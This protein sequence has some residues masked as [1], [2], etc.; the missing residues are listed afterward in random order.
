MAA[1]LR[2]GQPLNGTLTLSDASEQERSAIDQFLGRRPSSGMPMVVRL[3]EMERV[4]REGGICDSLCEAVQAI[5]G[6]IEN[7]RRVRDLAAE[8]WTELFTSLEP[9]MA[10]L[11][12]YR[13]WLVG[14]CPARLVQKSHRGG[15]ATPHR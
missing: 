3:A 12:E 1:R 14:I 13:D 4:L 6:P 7:Q 11:P 8:R 15:C 5:V 10:E 9:A 2:S